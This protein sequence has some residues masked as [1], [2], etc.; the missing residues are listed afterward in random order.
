[1]GCYEDTA[2]ELAPAAEAAVAA[3]D[4]TGGERVLDVACGTGNAAA[5]AAAAGADV[6]GLDASPRL[7]D[8]ARDR[9][10]AGAFVLGDAAALPFADGEFDAAVSVFGVIFVHP[11]RR[12]AKELA[13][14]VRP[15]GRAAVTTWPP[16]GPLFAAVSLMRAAVERRR[17]PGGRPPVDWGDPAVLDSLL[18]PDGELTIAERELSYEESAPEEIWDRWERLHPTWIRARG[19][20]EPAG[21]WDAL[22]AACLAVM[23]DAGFGAGATSPYLLAVL[24]RR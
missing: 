16:R 23:R 20:L 17:P 14:V 10:P 1:M 12:A 8:V 15:G 9:V 19:V 7:L 5:L 21:E 13:R 2:A 4:L 11:A 3:L 6:T 22:R 24:K 18:G